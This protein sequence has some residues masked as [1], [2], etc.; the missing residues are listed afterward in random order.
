MNNATAKSRNPGAPESSADASSTS[1]D[2]ARCGQTEVRPQPC[3]AIGCAAFFAL[4]VAAQRY[5]LGLSDSV[6]RRP[7]WWESCA[8]HVRSAFS[9]TT[10]A[11]LIGIILLSGCESQNVREQH[12]TRSAREAAAQAAMAEPATTGYVAKWRGGP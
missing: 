10:V 8:D 6:R 7:A 5:L 3:S 12:S 11:A 1:P 2:G 4:C 9:R